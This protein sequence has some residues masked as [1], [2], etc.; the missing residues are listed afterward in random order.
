MRAVCS[1][2]WVTFYLTLLAR[3]D[4]VEHAVV[5]DPDPRPDPD[6]HAGPEHSSSRGEIARCAREHG[7]C[8]LAVAERVLPADLAAE[9]ADDGVTLAEEGIVRARASVARK[10]ELMRMRGHDLGAIPASFANGCAASD[11]PITKSRS[12]LPILGSDWN[13]RSGSCGCVCAM[14]RVRECVGVCWRMR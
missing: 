12:V 10:V 8:L 3:W 7:L 5:P 2:H 4:T 9:V 13:S 14:G 1:S 11:M 6:P